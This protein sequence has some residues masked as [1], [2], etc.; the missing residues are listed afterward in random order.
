M[1]CCETREKDTHLVPAFET[2][3]A[4]KRGPESA[5]L[6]PRPTPRLTPR[7]RFASDTEAYNP[8]N[9]TSEEPVVFQRRRGRCHTAPHGLLQS[10]VLAVPCAEGDLHLKKG[11]G[12]SAPRR[13]MTHSEPRLASRMQTRKTTGLFQTR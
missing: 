8:G 5:R 7:P 12:R 2:R 1:G 9:S 11:L 10:Q 4:N 3:Y 13:M 6:T